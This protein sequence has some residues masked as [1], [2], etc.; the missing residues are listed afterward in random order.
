MIETDHSKCSKCLLLALRHAIK[1]S[2]HWSIDWLMKLSWLLTIFQSDAISA[3]GHTSLV[4][5][6]HVPAFRFQSMSPGAGPLVWFSWKWM[7][8]ITV[9]SCCSNS[10]C[11]TSVKL[12]VTFT[13]QCTTCAQ[14][15]R[16]AVR[17]DANFTPNMRPPNNNNNNNNNTT[18][19]KAP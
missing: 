12:I 2:C 16:A 19:Y 1:E 13:Y 5:D 14:E 7:M 9:I 6:K 17:Q 18:T 15:H 11:H 10:C 4:T 8:H 3:H